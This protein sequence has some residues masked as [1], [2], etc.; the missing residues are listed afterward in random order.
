M[1]DDQKKLGMLDE[2]ISKA[3][4][5]ARQLLDTLIGD[6]KVEGD[7]ITPTGSPIDLIAGGIG[8]KIGGALAADAESILGNEIGSVGADVNPQIGQ[9]IGTKIGKNL[10]TVSNDISQAG[11]IVDSAGVQTP[12]VSGKPNYGT[13][14]APKGFSKYSKMADG[15]EVPEGFNEHVDSLAPHS[16]VGIP[17]SQANI[18]PPGFDEYVED[19]QKKEKFGSPTQQALTGLEGAAQGVLGPLAPLGEKALGIPEIDI[20]GR[21]EANPGIHAIGETAGLAGSLFTGIGEGALAAK[22][23][24]ALVGKLPEMAS[25]GARLSTGAAKAAIEN[26]VITG[27][28]E[29]SK[30]I[31]N[32]PAQSAQSAMTDVGL[33]GLIGG[34]IGGLLG[35]ISPL[36]QAA[37]GSKAGQLIEDFKGEIDHHLNNP[38]PLGSAHQELTDLYSNVKSTADKVY[39]PTGLKA[40]EVAAVVPELHPDM[41]AQSEE[42]TDKLNTQLRKMMKDPYSY[43]P[44]LTNKL[45]ADVEAYLGKVTNP[46]SSSADL[47]NATQDLKTQLQSYAKYEKRVAPFAEEYDFVRDAKKLASTAREALEDKKIWGKAAERQESINKAFTKFLPTLEDFE[48]KFTTEIAGERVID[49][50]KVATFVNS[51]GKESS[52]VRQTMLKNFIDA[53]NKYKDVI[54]DTHANL[55]LEN[56]VPFSSMATINKLMEKPSAG[57]KLAQIFIDKGLTEGGSKALGA[58][59]GA[60]LGS[61]VGHPGIGALVGSHVLGPFYKSVLPA[62][63]KP[64]IAGANSAQGAKATVDY[65]MSV[66]KGQNVISKAAKAVFTA[67]RSEAS[68]ALIPS[69][70]DRAKLDKQLKRFQEDPQALIDLTS[71]SSVGHYAPDHSSA[72]G[73]TIA[74]SVN[75]LNSL[76]PSRDKAAPLDPTPIPSSS[77]KAAFTN[78]ANIALK[79]TIVLNKVK[80]GTVTVN[81]IKSLMAMAPDAYKSMARD[82][83]NELTNHIKKGDAVPY[84]TKMGISLFLGQPMDSTMMPEA[85][86]SA[87]PAENNQS[88]SPQQGAKSGKPMGKNTATLGKA[89]NAALTPDQARQK[90]QDKI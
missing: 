17:N 32:D 53:S 15:G 49:S 74:Q 43:P 8:S 9:K 36:W 68:H 41:Y 76:R 64:L 54:A 79:P 87:Q 27:G 59:T 88:Q 66:V 83:T 5:A 22:G 67:G 45:N 86:I 69:E 58:G 24:E 6:K 21:K 73:Q 63:A 11:N 60:A 65:G 44:R 29:I 89:A 19:V 47:F 14:T 20:Q 18:A 46:D 30:M 61:I 35:G 40:Q 34:S 48:S 70:S 10:G 81:D 7:A 37:E 84:R 31:L 12:L 25:L 23:A 55:G 57:Q 39:G 38:D 33:S 82:L 56:P 42:I 75:Y 72:V 28:D 2:I 26:M 85:I 51:A 90:R 50:Q 62:L 71:K 13:V 78:A 80:D 52:K 3:G 16:D 4:P 1:A 77:E